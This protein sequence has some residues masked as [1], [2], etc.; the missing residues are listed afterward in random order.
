[1]NWTVVDTLVTVLPVVPDV[2][3]QAVR[4][5]SLVRELE[6]QTVSHLLD[7]D[8]GLVI[9]IRAG[10]YLPFGQAVGFRAIGVDLFHPAG[11]QPP[12]VVD[13]NLSVY[14]ELLMWA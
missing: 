11:F 10:E 7:D 2:Q 4:D 3:C 6:Y 13:E 5:Q 14:T 1:M 9:G 12:G 8:S